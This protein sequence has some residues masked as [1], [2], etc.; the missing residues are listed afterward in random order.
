MKKCAEKSQEI[1][2]VRLD[3]NDI[4][5][6]RNWWDLNSCGLSRDLY[7]LQLRSLLCRVSLI[8]NQTKRSQVVEKNTTC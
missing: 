1:I 6:Y 2:Y 8:Y 3:V 7:S 5:C 4:R